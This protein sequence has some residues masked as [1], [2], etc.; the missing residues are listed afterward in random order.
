LGDRA[1][2]LQRDALIHDELLKL[3]FEVAQVERCLQ[4]TMDRYGH[5]FR[6]DNHGQAMDAISAEMRPSA[7]SGTPPARPDLNFG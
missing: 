6:S 1:E 4:V 2:A 3:G 5:L 7:P